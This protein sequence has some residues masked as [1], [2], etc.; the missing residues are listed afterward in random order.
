MTSC[1]L[2]KTIKVIPIIVLIILA[3]AALFPEAMAPVDFQTLYVPYMPPNAEHLLGTNNIGRDLLS[4]LIFSTRISLVTALLATVVATSLG[5]LVGVTAGYFRGLLDE[6]LM[7]VTD[8]FLLLPGLPLIILLAAYLGSGF[9]V[10]AFVIGVT[11]WP[12]TARVVRAAV[13]Q[14]REKNFIRSA[15][16]MGA[17]PYY[18]MGK[19][20]LPQT[21]P[22]IL[23]K[24]TLAAASAMVS[25]AGVS[26]LGLGD[27]R[28]SSWGGML[29]DAF[30]GG[31]LLNGCYWWYLP[32]VVCISLAVLALTTLGRRMMQLE[33]AVFP[34]QKRSPK[35]P[36]EAMEAGCKELLQIKDLTV[37]FRTPDGKMT[38]AVDRID[39]TIQPGD[40][41]AV[42]GETGSGKSLLLAAIMGLLP[43]ES[44]RS[45]EI[46]YRGKNLAALPEKEMR[47]IRGKEIAYVPQGAGNALN[48][49]LSVPFQVAEPAMEHLRMKKDAALEKAEGMLRK[50]GISHP[51]KWGRD[52]PHQYSGGMIQR[53]LIAMGLISG[54]PLLLMDEPVKGLD[55]QNRA[56]VLEILKHLQT[57]AILMVTHDLTF[58][59]K[60]AT[61][62]VVMLDS[63]MVE[64]S[65]ASLFFKEPLHPYSKALIWAQPEQGLHVLV[66]TTAKKIAASCCPFMDRCPSALERCDAVPPL[67]KRKGRAVRCL[68]YDSQNKPSS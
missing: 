18:V 22:V 45:G 7:R 36:G 50:M 64:I 54:A 42:I 1:R 44:S 30:T 58:A 53:A 63:F 16:A 51:G 33:P 52:Y 14:V 20:V 17:G 13:L 10:I 49:L 57:E 9:T 60:W 62:I 4:E 28:Y 47:K 5:V 21:T 34:Q 2:E 65:P 25:E 3:A 24:G 23:A 37:A 6:W 35:F 29:H 31:G 61:K 19:H 26:F 68:L 41:L 55:P 32:P 40:R 66:R 11:S 43:E 27:S 46:R 8:M 56:A 59:Q 67:V 38:R 15:R 12:S 48:P 39:L